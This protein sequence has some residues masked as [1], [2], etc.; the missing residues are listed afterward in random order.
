MSYHTNGAINDAMLSIINDGNGGM[1][2]MTYKQRCD[3]AETG[4]GLFRRAVKVYSDYAREQFGLRKL[5][6]AEIIETATELQAYYRRH[7]K[8]SEGA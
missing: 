4:I 6:R 3:A 1:C 2:G 8:E 7:V 5:T